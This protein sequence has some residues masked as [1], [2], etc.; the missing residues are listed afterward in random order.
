MTRL[1]EE[2]G[3]SAE[4]GRTSQGEEKADLSRLRKKAQVIG[5]EQQLRSPV[6]G[7]RRESSELARLGRR[8]RPEGF[9]R[10]SNSCY[11]REQVALL[12]GSCAVEWFREANVEPL[13]LARGD[14]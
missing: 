3:I 4:P 11:L 8:C 1:L 10:L 12:E 9:G 5:E 2:C 14:A 6:L 13:A 7:G